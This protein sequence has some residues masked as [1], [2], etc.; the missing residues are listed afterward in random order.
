M[1]KFYHANNNVYNKH[2]IDDVTPII[3]LILL[4][5]R[6]EK[7]QNLINANWRGDTSKNSNTCAHA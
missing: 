2:D 7:E 4:W 6:R 1:I 3:L 5:E